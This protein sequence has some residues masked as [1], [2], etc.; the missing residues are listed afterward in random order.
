[1]WATG[2][3]ELFPGIYW[4]FLQVIFWRLNQSAGYGGNGVAPHLS[5]AEYKL[6]FM[7]RNK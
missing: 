5:T 3:L 1:M 7:E 6:I 2:L 4:G